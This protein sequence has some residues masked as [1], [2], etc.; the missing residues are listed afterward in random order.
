MQRTFLFKFLC[1]ELLNT[2]LIRQHL[3]QCAELSVELQQK[4]RSISV[5]WKNLKLKEENL[6]AR[7][8][9][10]DSGLIHV[11]GDVGTEEGLASAVTNNGKC[12][13]KPQSLSDRP[14]DFGIFSNDQ[15]QREGGCEGIKSKGLD[16][17][18]SNNFSEGNSTLKP[19]DAEGQLKEI[20]TVVDETQ[21]SVDHFPHVVYQGNGNSCRSNELAAQDP[22]HQERDG[23]GT[24]SNL[25]VNFCENMEKND[26]Q[27]FHHPSDIRSAHVAKHD[28]VLNSIKSD[29]SHLQDSMASI[30]S[31]L[32]ELSVRR[33]FLGRDSAGR[34][35]WILAKPGRHPCVL[36]DGSV[37]LQ[38]KG[39]KRFLKNPGD[40]SVLKNSTSL[41]MDILSTPGGSNASYPF[42]YKR[43]ASISSCSQ[44]VSYQSDKE[45]DAL[46]GWLKDS[47]PR[48]KELKESI[49]H[50]QKLRFRDW[51]LTGDPDQCDS[52]TTLSR[53]TNSENAFSDGIL[54]KAATLLE[55]KYGPCFEPEIVDISKKWEQ[56]SK[57]TNEGKMYRCECLEPIWSSRHHCSSCHRTFFT[58][59]QLEEHNDGSCRSA[60]PT[61]EKSKENSSHLKGKRSF[62]AKTSLED[63][64]GDIDMVEI[65]KGGCSQP[66]SRLIK[67]QNEGLVCPYDFEEI[68]LKFVTKNS[69]RELVQGIGLI[70]SKGVPSFVSSRPPYVIDDTLLLVP[71]KKS[72]DVPSDE[73]KASGDMMLSQGNRIPIEGSGSFSDSSSRDS[74]ANE[75]S[76]ASKTDKP[77]LEQKDKKYSLNHHGPEMEVGRCFVIPQSSLRRLVGKDYQ[78]LRQLK[79]NLL[80]MDA[81][82]PEEALRPSRV[83]LEK[84][85]AWQAFVKSAETIFEV[86]FISLVFWGNKC[87]SRY[88]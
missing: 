78:V 76:A 41:G 54:T 23:L 56:R 45:I 65:P 29:I 62:K 1:D 74:A 38:N 7:A 67:F 69:N 49:L 84:R 30:E 31:Q 52:Q 28:S 53:F 59:I 12:M 83:N 72:I 18:P 79:I 2:A 85:L 47:D 4:L 60:P 77:A 61:S 34:L 44:W 9:K 10:V 55:K 32:L 57:L 11:A 80:D 13:E 71:S 15:L 81:A 63:S 8:P 58:D 48:E 40:S 21:G 20:H 66:G 26:L 14:K 64:T 16:R 22:L 46:I 43:K 36:V 33:E 68:C 87:I 75:T 19:I 3:E 25:Q 73:L 24:E 17:Q 37:A 82:L 27:G 86:R 35:Y 39:N 50:L 88:C 51:K 42:L 5:E 6:A 70:D